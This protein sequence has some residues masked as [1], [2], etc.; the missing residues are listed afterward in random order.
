MMRIAVRTRSKVNIEVD[1][2]VSKNN[3]K[4]RPGY[5][6]EDAILEN[7]LVHDKSLVTEKHETRMIT[8]L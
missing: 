7:I 2:R 3:H 1:D 8:D 4:S 6:I 5:S